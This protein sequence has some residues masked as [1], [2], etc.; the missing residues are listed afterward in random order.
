M[1]WHALWELLPHDNLHREP[2]DF[3]APNLPTELD[4][5]KKQLSF[6]AWKKMP[7]IKEHKSNGELDFQTEG[8]LVS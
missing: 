3:S 7:Y 8:I 1:S 6:V 5:K 2:W 4:K